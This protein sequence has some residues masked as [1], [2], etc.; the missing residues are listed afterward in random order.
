[1]R[2]FP[3][4]ECTI[5]QIVDHCLLGTNDINVVVGPLA[6]RPADGTVAKY[7]YFIVCTSEAKRGFRCDQVIVPEPDQ[8]YRA[9]FILELARRKPKVVHDVDSELA[10]AKLCETLWP[11]ERITNLRKRVEREQ[12]S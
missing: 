5:Q 9:A 8:D 6:W 11:G 4:D 10:M 3:T 7:W 2:T 12:K 1:M